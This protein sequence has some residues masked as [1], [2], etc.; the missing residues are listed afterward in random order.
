MVYGL[1]GKTLQAGSYQ[2]I[3]CV[4]A[5]FLL[6][7]LG[8]LSNPT[9]AETITIATAANF[10]QTLKALHKPFTAQTSDTINIVTGSSGALA[11][12]IINGAP[13]D[14]F[15][16]ADEKR[17]RQLVEKGFASEASLTIYAYGRLTLWSHDKNLIANNDGPAVL[18]AGKFRHIAIANP[19]LAPYG[20][21]STETL[22]SLNLLYNLSD[23]TVR[24]ENIAQTF[25][26]LATGAAP[27]RLHRPLTTVPPAME[28][29]RQ[30]LAR[31]SQFSSADQAGCYCCQ[32]QQ[33]PESRPPIYGVFEKQPGKGNYPVIWL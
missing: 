23:K 14:V 22:R 17:P 1:T 27:P 26:M 8:L 20:V 11:T 12:Q 21:A 5:F 10:Q 4:P 25:T 32:E 28:R 30:P 33:N 29:N 16:S 13:F 7:I 15:L 9:A 18:T 2:F 24:G 19:A 31:P 3:L 6:G